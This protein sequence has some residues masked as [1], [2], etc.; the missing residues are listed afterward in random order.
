MRANID[1]EVHMTEKILVP[2]DGTD[3]AEQVVPFVGELA[4]AG[5]YEVTLLTII[6]PGD[7]DVTETA[8]EG[9]LSAQDIG[10]GASGGTD[11]AHSGTGGTTGMVWMAPVGSPAELS[12]EEAEELDKA[13]Q[14]ARTYLSNVEQKLESLGVTTDTA[15]GFGNPDN[16]IAEEAAKVG[17]SMIA[18]AARSA[19]IWERG[20]LGSTTDRVVNSSPMPVIVFKPMEGLAHAITV[21]PETIVVALDG[22][23]QG[24]IA[25][26]P[27]RDLAKRL[28]AQISLVHVLKRDTP[29]RR[30]QAESYLSRTAQKIG[31][32]ETA[33][34]SGDFDEEIILY[35]DQFEK[36]MIAMTEH[37]GFS[38]GRWLRG[39]TTDKVIRNAGYPV[40]VVPNAD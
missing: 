13:N 6:N 21:K 27:A 28:D 34:V 2:L 33:V 38:I 10:T 20:V 7:L 11:L 24:E 8:G 29:R 31:G 9:I 19:A 12:K 40:L 18:M 26:T 16:E 5:G 14:A 35:A 17:A 32:A 30:E 25:L 36:P 3:T 22:S 39:S 15:L 37:G 1:L 23:G 4:K